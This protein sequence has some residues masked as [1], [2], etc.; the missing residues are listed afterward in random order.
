M[1]YTKG[2]L[3]K[4]IG[5]RVGVQGVFSK[6]RQWF[7]GRLLKALDSRLWAWEQR[8]I[9]AGAGHLTGQRSWSTAG[10]E[11][12]QRWGS[13]KQ[14]GRSQISTSGISCKPKFSMFLFFCCCCYFTSLANLEF[15]FLFLTLCRQ[16][17]IAGASLEV[18]SKGLCR[19]GRHS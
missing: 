1:R 3:R 14:I 15:C 17:S 7:E 9:D 19:R 11:I 13:Q 2:S 5:P 8:G 18:G 6:R 4:Q 12:C 10:Y 16:K